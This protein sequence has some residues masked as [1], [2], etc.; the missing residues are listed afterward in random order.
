MSTTKPEKKT[1]YAYGTSGTGD[2]ETEFST[3]LAGYTP[4][5]AQKI[6]QSFVVGT[7]NGNPDF[8]EVNMDYAAA[9]VIEKFHPNRGWP[10][11]GTTNGEDITPG[12]VAKSSGAG[13]TT[14][15]AEGAAKTSQQKIGELIYGKSA[16]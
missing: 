8:G 1:E 15:P 2:L 11:N 5:I 4:E 13:S 6:Q 12:P 3:A 16:V 7:Q 10:A 14:S 9:P